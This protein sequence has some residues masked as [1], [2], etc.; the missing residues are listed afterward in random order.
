MVIFDTYL[1]AAVECFQRGARA[2]ALPGATSPLLT[3]T[4]RAPGLIS[5]TALGRVAAAVRTNF[6]HAAAVHRASEA[7]Q[8]D[9][10]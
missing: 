7:M 1:G 9:V 6:E 2:G 4:A 5:H 3:C 8:W 10:A